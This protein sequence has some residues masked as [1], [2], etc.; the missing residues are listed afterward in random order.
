M[1]CCRDN[2]HN[3]QPLSHVSNTISISHYALC[4]HSLPRPAARQRNQAGDGA[5]PL[6]CSSWPHRSACRSGLALTPGVEFQT[7]LNVVLLCQHWAVLH[8]K[9]PHPRT[10]VQHQSQPGC[11]QL[12][13]L[14]SPPY[15]FFFVHSLQVRLERAVRQR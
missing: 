4:A 8:L 12:P 14:T 1:L 15:S 2:L 13:L 9:V 10:H 3:A 6:L 5:Q 11:C 7:T